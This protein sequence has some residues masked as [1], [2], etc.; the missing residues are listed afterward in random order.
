MAADKKRRG[1][2]ELIARREELA[3]VSPP[4]T[5]PAHDTGSAGSAAEGIAVP[6][7]TDLRLSAEEIV[8]SLPAPHDPLSTGPELI[9]QEREEL[10]LYENAL[11]LAGEMFWVEGHS[12]LGISR[13]E[14]WRETHPSFKAYLADRDI[15]PRRAYQ[16]MEVAPLGEYLH[17]SLRKIFHSV[18]LNEAQTK[19]LLPLAKRHGEEAAAFVMETVLRSG[20]KVTAALLKGALTV[21]PLDR[22]DRQEVE[23]LLQEYLTAKQRVLP[24]ESSE[25]DADPAEAWP[26]EADRLRTVVRR[27][28][29]RPEFRAAARARP[30]EARAVVAEL[31]TL[32]DEVEA[33]AL[34]EE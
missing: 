6:A 14:L 28:V 32:L 3:D 25:G 26:A 16:L 2:D 12:L 22:F 9:P 21:L 1:F 8:K 20:Q 31:R 5:A 27:V 34:T 18:V 19:T 13:G 23:K 24:A 7:E 11:N 30:D 15:S 17:G 4:W 29:S 33:A 10:E